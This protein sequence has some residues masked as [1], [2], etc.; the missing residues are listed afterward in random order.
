MH[1]RITHVMTQTT[2]HLRTAAFAWGVSLRH[3]RRPE[4]S[5]GPCTHALHVIN[6][7]YLRTVCSDT[8]RFVHTEKHHSSVNTY[9]SVKSAHSPC[10]IQYSIYHRSVQIH[11]IPMYTNIIEY[12]TS[13]SLRKERPVTG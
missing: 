8:L 9:S 12:S 5:M 10:T 7:M 1:T 2:A 6:M 3:I 11:V 4:M 13:Y